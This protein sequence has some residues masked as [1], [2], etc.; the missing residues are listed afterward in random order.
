MK[1]F[2]R[3][4]GPPCGN[5][6]PD[7]RAPS[8]CPLPEGRGEKRVRACGPRPP[9]R[10]GMEDDRLVRFLSV[11]PHGYADGLNSHPIPA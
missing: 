4:S 5:R 3:L 8:P 10:A 2:P 6:F 1:P 9:C 7:R 11:D